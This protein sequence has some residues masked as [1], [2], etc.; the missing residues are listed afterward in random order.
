MAK[1]LIA[2]CLFATFAHAG[3]S[4]H[5]IQVHFGLLLST[6]G[7]LGALCGT[8]EPIK[9]LIA[10][11]NWNHHQVNQFCGCF[12][13]EV[14][15]ATTATHIANS[16]IVTHDAIEEAIRNRDKHLDTCVDMMKQL[17]Q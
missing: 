4:E 3:D 16:L 9:P 5:D 17:T 2:L 8:S 7:M 12:A 1:Y 10:K 13:M 15:N 11:F 14:M 6:S